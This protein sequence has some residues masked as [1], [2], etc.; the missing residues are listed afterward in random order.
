MPKFASEAEFHGFIKA[1]LDTP[2]TMNELAERI[3]QLSEKLKGEYWLPPPWYF[4]KHI[5]L[6]GPT[7][8]KSPDGKYSLAGGGKQ[9][10]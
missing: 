4:E 5:Q 3:A 10:R 7:I 2:A 6:I 9:R 8:T 1:G